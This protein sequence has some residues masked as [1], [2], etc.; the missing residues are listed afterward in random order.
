MME[1]LV[2]IIY[3][4]VIV[5]LI[6]SKPIVKSDSVPRGS[7]YYRNSGLIN[8]IVGNL[9]M[10]AINMFLRDKGII[11]Q[12]FVWIGIIGFGLTMVYGC[13][14]ICRMMFTTEP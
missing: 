6:H 4:I 8:I 14:C 2:F 1:N 5:Q 9:G 3:G 10:L 11:P 12:T 13:Y 7:H